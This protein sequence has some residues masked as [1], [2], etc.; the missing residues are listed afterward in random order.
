MLD[1]LVRPVL[2]LRIYRALQRDHPPVILR[3]WAAQLRR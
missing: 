3:V 1:L 2:K